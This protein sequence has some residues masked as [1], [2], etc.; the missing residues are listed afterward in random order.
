MAF[1]TPHH[2][3]KLSLMEIH[4]VAFAGRPGRFRLRSIHGPL[5]QVQV[6]PYLWHML[7]LGTF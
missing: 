6:R 4:S 5:P 2:V 7:R 1:Y 3:T